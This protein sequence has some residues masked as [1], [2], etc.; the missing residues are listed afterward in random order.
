[1][2]VFDGFEEGREEE[3]AIVN[4]MLEAL[5]EELVDKI[6]FFL[7]DNEDAELAGMLHDRLS[8]AIVKG[9]ED[10]HDPHLCLFDLLL[11]FQLNL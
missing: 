6:L 3:Q 7:S 11:N 1:M 5:V 8:D 4:G 9:F 2:K 10:G